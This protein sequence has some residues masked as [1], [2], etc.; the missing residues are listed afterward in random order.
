MQIYTSIYFII[1]FYIFYIIFQHTSPYFTLFVVVF[2]SELKC[3]CNYISNSMQIFLHLTSHC[4]FFSFLSHADTFSYQT[5]F[6]KALHCFEFLERC[7]AK[8]QSEINAMREAPRPS[9]SPRSSS[10]CSRK[11]TPLQVLRARA[12]DRRAPLRRTRDL[13]A[14]P[15]SR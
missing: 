12:A 15:E 13:I 5:T 8:T 9:V 6:K 7:K 2:Y 11:P 4:F 14:T 10:A 3:N 1:Y